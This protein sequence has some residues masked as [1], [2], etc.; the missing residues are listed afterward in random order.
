MNRIYIIT[1]ICFSLQAQ[2]YEDR[3]KVFDNFT[4]KGAGGEQF[5]ELA[6]ENGA[7]TIRTWATRTDGSTKALLDKAQSL[8]LKVE[9]GFWMPN[10]G[11]NNG[12]NFDWSDS[13]QYQ[14]YEEKLK[15]FL[16]SLDS[17]PAVPG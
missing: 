3:I 11:D 15:V 1:L 8:G 10:Q 4:I 14:P 9:M 12:W 6:K 13:A 7:N 2:T 17:H 5:L 16:D